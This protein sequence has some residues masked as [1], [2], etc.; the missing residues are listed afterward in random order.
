MNLK[1]T[2]RTTL[3]RVATMSLKV[4]GEEV[5]QADIDLEVER[6]KP[7]YDRF[8]RDQ[9]PDGS[10]EQLLVWSRE[11]LVERTLIRQQASRLPDPPPDPEQ[12]EGPEP[13]PEYVLQRKVDQL[14]QSIGDR[15]EPP[16]DKDLRQ[17]Y[18]TNK[19]DF[20]NPEQLRASHIVK[21]TD[22]GED[23]MQAYAEILNVKS[24][25]DKGVPFE[26]L[27]HKHS[28]CPG[29]GGDLGY[30]GRGQMVQEFEDVVFA[31][32]TDEVSAVFETPF[33]FHIAK[34]YDR[35]AG[36]T[37]PFE[38]VKEPIAAQLTQERRTRALEAY[39]DELKKEAVIEEP[40][41]D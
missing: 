32:K 30:F 7:D 29:S 23:R 35:R 27:A 21:H 34:V 16:T 2:A 25:L 22:H 13:G 20:R 4:N 36:G 12:D 8:V 17:Y 18:R 38:Q 3:S 31:L 33:G 6:L 40:A 5:P 28:D 41:S 19:Q 15:A 26:E 24:Q 1:K 14:V 10:D 9:N 37:V 39:V 11:N